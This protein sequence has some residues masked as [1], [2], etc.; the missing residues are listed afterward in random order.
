MINLFLF[1]MLVGIFSAVYVL[2]LA[3]EPVLNW[4]FRFGLNYE[5][6]WFYKPIWGCH[7]CVSGQIMLWIFVFNWIASN[8]NGN[9][10]FWRFL[11]S[12]IPEYHFNN[13]SVFFGAFVIAQTIFWSFVTGELIKYLKNIN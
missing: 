5:N 11:F 9:A 13:Y 8:L 1:C 2:I 10:P 7:L 4:W 12:L 3:K 6:R